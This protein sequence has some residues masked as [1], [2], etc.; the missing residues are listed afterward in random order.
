MVRS[1]RVASLRGR[2]EGWSLTSRD[3][4]LYFLASLFALGTWLTSTDLAQWRWGEMAVGP[5]ALATLVSLSG[6]RLSHARRVALGVALF[7]AL[8]VPL[9]VE[10]LWRVHSP[11]GGFAQPEV[12][13]LE[14]AALAIFHGHT[15]YVAY[16]AHGH[17]VNPVAH[18]AP[19]ESF[20]PYFPLIAVFGWPAVLAHSITGWGD[21][22]VAITLFSVLVTLLGVRWLSDSENVRIRVL[23]YAVAL[24]TGAL[25][26]VTG[27]D[28]LPILALGLLAVALAHRR[29]PG[30]AGVVIGVAAAMKFT[31]WPL[32]LLLIVV[33]RDERGRHAGV[34]VA[35]AVASVVAVSVLP[36]LLVNPTTFIANVVAFPLGLSHVAS[37]A[38][39]PLPGHL[40][41]EWSP[42]LGHLLVVLA[43]LAVGLGA[44]MVARRRWP[45]DLPT[46]L[47]V[48]ALG[49][50]VMI[51]VASA[52]RS[53][54]LIY[55]LEMA[56]WGW[57]AKVAKEPARDLQL[58]GT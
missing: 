4:V 3:A 56:V 31:A 27:G 50:L 6:R 44:I 23:Q 55:P 49:T 18:G 52:T 45:L 1:D 8:V 35:T 28:D 11:Y 9:V 58:L 43:V 36:P 16:W 19:Y 2:W 22:R 39:S 29:R 47:S 42:T 33:A 57:A 46:A 54:Y 30:A 13:V 34:R 20:F 53:G 15:P 17:L 48:L 32:A 41:S 37:P 5:Y 40:I 51:S 7:G 10:V 26:A 12:M 14:R 38:A 21:A 24:P 25:F